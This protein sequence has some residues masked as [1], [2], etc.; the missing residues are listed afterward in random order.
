ML[1]KPITQIIIG[2]SV[3]V[4]VGSSLFFEDIKHTVKPPS[5]NNPDQAETYLFNTEIVSLNE[6][7]QISQIIV[8]PSTVQGR[9]TKETRIIKPQI[10][11]FK[12]STLAWQISAD[13]ASIS[14]DTSEM[15]LQDNVFLVNPNNNTQLR[16]DELNYNTLRQIATSESPITVEANGAKMTANGLRFNLADG[17]YQLNNK[18]TAHYDR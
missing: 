17:Y 10:S 16:T 5:V 13:T 4:A 2:L 1:R 9:Y 14:S 15:S 11:L 8:T 7:G 18:V 6:A 12:D 3:A